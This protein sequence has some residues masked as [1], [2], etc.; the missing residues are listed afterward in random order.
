MGILGWFKNR[1]D[2]FDPDRVTDEMRR[3][4]IDKAITLTN[5]RLKLLPS[6]EKQLASA[7]DTTIDYLRSL[8]P[9]L[10]AVG[11]QLGRRPGTARVLRQTGRH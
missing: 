4:A 6:C 2:H 3:W 10:P 1:P 5:P 7:V 9:A 11:S 8:V